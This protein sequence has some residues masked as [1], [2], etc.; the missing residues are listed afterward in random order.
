M[1]SILPYYHTNQ[2]N[3][4]TLNP[5]LICFF[6]FVFLFDIPFIICDFYYGFN[7]DVCNSDNKLQALNFTPKQYLIATAFLR[8]GF[9]L[10]LIPF[11]FE[12]TNGLDKTGSFFSIFSIFFA[13]ITFLVLITWDILG[14]IVFWTTAF[15]KGQCNGNI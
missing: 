13:I 10:F 11:S 14:G 7:S 15:D 4:G 3:R 9:L 8:L 5:V 2:L 6:I 12:R 1:P